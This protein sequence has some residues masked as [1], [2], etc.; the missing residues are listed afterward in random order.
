MTA[1]T[2]GL[3]FPPTDDPLMTQVLLALSRWVTPRHADP[4]ESVGAWFVTDGTDP[5]LVGA[6][7]VIVWSRSAAAGWP[8]QVGVVA[9]PGRA[10]SSGDATGWVTVPEPGVDALATPYVPPL[11]RRR[12]RQRLRLPDAMVVALDSPSPTDHS[13]ETRHLELAVSAVATGRGNAVLAA[14]AHGLPLVTDSA[15]AHGL[16]LGDAAVVAEVR[17]FAATATRLATSEE[18]MAVLAWRGRTLVEERFD[19][20]R[21][22]WR[23]LRAVLGAHALRDDT[24]GVSSLLSDLWTPPRAAL[25]IAHAIEG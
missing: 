20:A 16:G 21:A 23:L 24:F 3:A 25:E 8:G 13:D 14:L 1:A 9:A 18:R 5:G 15:T 11:L 4:D 17:D 19:I 22:A 12:W 10:P 7:P 2:L 6:G